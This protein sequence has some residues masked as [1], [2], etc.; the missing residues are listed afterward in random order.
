MFI[1]DLKLV[2]HLT[3]F[4]HSMGVELNHGVFEG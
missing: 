4:N 3:D 1:L 2:K